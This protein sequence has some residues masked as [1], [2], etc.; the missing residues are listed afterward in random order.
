MA[1]AYA[2]ASQGFFN[3]LSRIMDRNGTLIALGFDDA[4][5]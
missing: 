4:Q 1:D 2:K 5:V 3:T